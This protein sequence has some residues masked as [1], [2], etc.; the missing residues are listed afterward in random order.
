MIFFSLFGFVDTKKIKNDSFLKYQNQ[1]EFLVSANA[2]ENI[3]TANVNSVGRD[4]IKFTVYDIPSEFIPSD[5]TGEVIYAF[6]LDQNASDSADFPN[7]TNIKVD[8][9][10]LDSNDQT[11]DFVFTVSDLDSSTTYEIY[12]IYGWYADSNNPNDWIPFSDGDGNNEI[13]LV[14]ESGE[15][16][17][18]GTTKIGSGYFYGIIAI[19]IVV[20][21]L[22]ILI[23]VLFLVRFKDYRKTK[24]KYDLLNKEL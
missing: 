5:L 20:F 14:N 3:Y 6:S 22:L 17:I 4:S 13:Q 18:S 21:I 1:A 16:G 23:I 24:E 2:K 7:N 11:Y 10:I 8:E 9:V 15:A 19:S 12:S